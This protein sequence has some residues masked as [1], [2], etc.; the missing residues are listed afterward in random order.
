MG[1]QI[2]KALCIKAGQY[3]KG[4]PNYPLHNCDFSGSEE[5]GDIL[6]QAMELGSTKNWRDVLQLITGERKI[7][8]QA[9]VEFYK[10]LE[11]WL[12][13]QNKQLANHVGWDTSESKFFLVG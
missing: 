4:D 2:Y 10:P 13:E 3:I 6:K 1:Y 7:N 11:N 9:I 5:A 12:R 8:G